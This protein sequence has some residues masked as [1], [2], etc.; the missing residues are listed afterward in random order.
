[1]K[2]NGARETKGESK[3]YTNFNQTSNFFFPPNNIS[4]P[5][6]SITGAW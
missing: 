2:K 1:M 5:A 4:P 3:G 6:E